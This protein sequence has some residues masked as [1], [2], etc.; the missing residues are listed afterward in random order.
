MTL[1]SMS[2]LAI[3]NRNTLKEHLVLQTNLAIDN[4][5]TL[6]EHLVLQTNLAIDNRNTLKEHLVLQTNLA[7][8]N[9]NMLKEH[10]VLQTNLAIDNRNTLKEHLVLQTNL[11]IDNRNT[12][13]EHL[14]LQTNLAI[15]NRN[16][17]KE[18]LVLQM[19]LIHNPLMKQEGRIH[20]KRFMLCARH[21]LKHQEEQVQEEQATLLNVARLYFHLFSMPLS[22]TYNTACDLTIVTSFCKKYSIDSTRCAEELFCFLQG[23]M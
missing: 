1:L 12:L 9:R 17:L 7:I 18:H 23:S 6:K 2:N 14:V 4:R 10:L 22:N 5:N 15:D 11:A 13:K 21:Y 3:D 20:T 16:T 19:S 8:D